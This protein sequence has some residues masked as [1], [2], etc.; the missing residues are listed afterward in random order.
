MNS[1]VYTSEEAGPPYV[2]AAV[3]VPEPN[4]NQGE[5]DQKISPWRLL[6][7]ILIA[8]IGVGLGFI[9]LLPNAMMASYTQVGA[10]IGMIASAAFGIGGI[11]GA[12]RVEWCVSYVYSRYHWIYSCP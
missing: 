8:A 10:N 2:A 9:T 4:P 7:R 3:P 5:D 12:V 11:V 6:Q 1:P